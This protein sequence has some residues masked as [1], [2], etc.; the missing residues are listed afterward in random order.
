MHTPTSNPYTAY[1]KGVDENVAI[2]SK[3]GNVDVHYQ[4]NRISLTKVGEWHLQCVAFVKAVTN[5]GSAEDPING[6]K[7]GDSI[8]Q[9]SNLPQFTPVAVFNSSGTYAGNYAKHAA[10]LMK[11]EPTGIYLLDQNHKD[12]TYG[13]SPIGQIAYHFVP[14]DHDKSGPSNAYNY[15]VILQ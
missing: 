3:Y 12:N 7:K 13:L 5:S 1:V 4:F 11:V 14:F 15:S 8:S 2:L 10:L 9:F 6:W